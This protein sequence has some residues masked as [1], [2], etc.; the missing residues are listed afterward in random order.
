MVAVWGVHYTVYVKTVPRN[1]EAERHDHLLQE[2]LGQVSSYNPNA[3]AD[4]IKRAFDYACE[5]H[6]GQ[7]RKSGEEFIH[8][9]WSVGQI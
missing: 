9:P 3:D 7:L 5:H 6:R 8:H 1:A 2:L 4:L